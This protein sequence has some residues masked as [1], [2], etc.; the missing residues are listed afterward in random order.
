M[1]R[2]V[3][4][5]LTYNFRTLIKFEFIYKMLSVFILSPLFSFF[6]KLTM[7]ITGYKYITIENIL[8]FFKQ[9]L[10]I[11]MIVIV[12]L[13]TALYTLFEINTIIVLFDASKQRVKVGLRQTVYI[14][15]KK[16]LN[17]LKNPT[18]LGIIFIVLFLIPFLNLGITTSF[19]SSFKIPEY[20]MDFI[21][22]NLVYFITYIFV[23]ALLT[24]VLFRWIYVL[25]YHV[26]ENKSFYKARKLSIKL[27]K[28]HRIKDLIKLFITEGLIYLFYIVFVGFGIFIIVLINKYVTSYVFVNS[29]LITLIWLYLAFSFILFTLLSTPISYAAISYLFYKNKEII[30]EETY[31]VNFVEESEDKKKFS[32]VK[33]I[34]VMILIVSGTYYTYGIQKKKFDINIEH[35]RNIEV[36]AHRGASKKYPEN[37]ML[38]FKGARKLGADWIEL[39]V[40]QTK[41]GRI[42]VIHDSNLKRITGLKKNVWEL[43]YDEINALD[44]GSHFNKKYKGEKIPLLEEVIKWAKENKVKL[45]I[46]LKPTG[47]E[48]NFEQ[49]VLDIINNYGYKNSVVV[50][51]QAYEVL[52]NIKKIDKKIKTVYVMSIAYGDIN[53]LKYADGFSI[54][55][56]NINNKLIFKIHENGKK[57][58][59]WTINKESSISE[60]INYNVDNIITDDV[61]LAQELIDKSKTSNVILDYIKFIED[62]F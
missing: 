40:Q 35:T 38:A 18:N 60:M 29:L 6:I 46:E 9:P 61:S 36:T 24:I 17:L 62:L 19:I 21:K 53:K 26:L 44:A 41:D 48:I 34:I 3:V 43:T 57:I 28:G 30:N 59:A 16:T 4:K 7:K 56:S 33:L 52:I 14:S 8:S 45:N 54:E 20:I 23:M 2:K 10:T 55:A 27:G 5:L 37:T 58:Y 13:L 39:D 42:I 25:N 50:T 32:I 1:F 47:H 12:S 49:S 22:S 51:S 31:S 11:T 15:M